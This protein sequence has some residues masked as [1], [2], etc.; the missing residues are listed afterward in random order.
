[1]KYSVQNITL[2]DN[3]KLVHGTVVPQTWADNN[4]SEKL[5]FAIRT[6]QYCHRMGFQLSVPR[7]QKD[8]DTILRLK[9]SNSGNLGH[10]IML[11]LG[12]H[13]N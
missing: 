13:N 5:N 11:G 9:R 12:L 6:I 4:Q 3:L 7:S 8:I 2:D 1:M 10:F